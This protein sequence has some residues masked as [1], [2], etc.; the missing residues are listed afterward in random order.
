M[1]MKGS[2]RFCKP[3]RCCATQASEPSMTAQ[4]STSIETLAQLHCNID[5]AKMGVCWHELQVVGQELHGIG[6]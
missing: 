4:G 1:P 2:A 6:I 5:D 3:T